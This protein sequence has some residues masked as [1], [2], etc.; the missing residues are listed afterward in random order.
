MKGNWMD[1][2][3]HT[4]IYHSLG[5]PIH[6]KFSV[7]SQPLAVSHHSVHKCSWKIAFII[8]KLMYK[9]MNSTFTFLIISLHMLQILVHNITVQN[10]F[11]I[12]Y[13]LFIIMVTQPCVNINSFLLLFH[14]TL[15]LN[16]WDLT[17]CWVGRNVLKIRTSINN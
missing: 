13:V 4:G 1:T 15:L 5:L 9:L 17:V 10:C 6:P 7:T 14:K 12:R 2:V 8:H 16:Q 3:C 11:L